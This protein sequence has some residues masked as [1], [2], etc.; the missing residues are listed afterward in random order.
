MLL[1][2]NNALSKYIQI[3]GDSIALAATQWLSLTSFYLE[4]ECERREI[5]VQFYIAFCGNKSK[6]KTTLDLFEQTK[7]HADKV[8]DSEVAET[9]RVLLRD[10]YRVEE[11]WTG[12]LFQMRWDK[13]LIGDDEKVEEGQDKFKSAQEQAMAALKARQNQ[14]AEMMMDMSSSE[15][16]DEDDED[17]D[18]E[19]EEMSEDDVDKEATTKE[20]EEEGVCVMCRSST[21]DGDM[22]GYVGFADTF[23]KTPY[24][25]FCGHLLHMSCRDKY[26]ASLI[27]QRM[28]DPFAE[29]KSEDVE[30]GEFTY[31][32]FYWI[33]HSH[34]FDKIDI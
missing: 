34:L 14:F 16:D 17:E 10:L 25:S 31:V 15:E 4:R 9:I 29:L 20:E 13:D 24:V 28:R 26:Q 33:S 3:D 19:D 11:R 27:Q 8:G 30:N 5:A 21:S 7:R 32:F 12:G 23:H 2:I 18:D 22:L 6:E 1:L